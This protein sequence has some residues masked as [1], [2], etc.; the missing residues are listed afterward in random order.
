MR[1]NRLAHRAGLASNV[2]LLN[3]S[4]CFRPR[5]RKPPSL[6]AIGLLPVALAHSGSGLATKFLQPAFWPRGIAEMEMR[7]SEIIRQLAAFVRDGA[8]SAAVEYAL[9]ATVLVLAAVSAVSAVM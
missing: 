4:S 2:H 9:A 3:H 1:P 5:I 7:V 8:G 6:R